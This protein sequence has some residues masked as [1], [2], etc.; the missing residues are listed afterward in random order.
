MI[1][2]LKHLKQ[3]HEALSPNPEWVEKSRAM[4]MNQIQNSTGGSPEPASFSTSIETFFNLFVSERAYYAVRKIGRASCRER[5]SS[6][7]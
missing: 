7:V 5:V 1:S 6:P 4:I 3:N 2:Q